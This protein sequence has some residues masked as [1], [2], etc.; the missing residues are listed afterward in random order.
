MSVNIS[1]V[2]L[3]IKLPFSVQIISY[4]A[5]SDGPMEKIGKLSLLK[6]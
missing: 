1:G 3:S 6:D 5:A 2:E 4:L